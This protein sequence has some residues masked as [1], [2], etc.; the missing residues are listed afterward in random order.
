VLATDVEAVYVDWGTP[1]Q[2]AITRTSAGRLRE[3]AFAAGSMGPKVESVCRFVEATG[4]RAAIG[5]LEDIPGL[6]EG[7]AGTQVT[8]E[9]A[10]GV[11]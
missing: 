1:D 11:A 3:L 10:A 8:S 5:R 6:I 7:V 4:R 9:E 2:Q